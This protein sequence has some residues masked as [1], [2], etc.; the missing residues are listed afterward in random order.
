MTSFEARDR[1]EH[2][3]RQM[4]SRR[5]RGDFSYGTLGWIVASESGYTTKRYT[6]ASTVPVDASL[7]GCAQSAY[8]RTSL[9]AGL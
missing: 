4:S 8:F 5:F 7:P 2:A 9:S 6:K 1:D 3:A